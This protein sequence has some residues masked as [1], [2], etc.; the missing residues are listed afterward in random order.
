MKRVIFLVAAFIISGGILVAQEAITG[1]I[2]NWDNG[3]GSVF[4]GM[5]TPT[6]VGTIDD[7]GALEIILKPDFLSEVKQ[8]MEAENADE[9]NK[10]K[11]SMMTLEKAYTCN[12]G[13]VE[14][15]NGDQH[16]TSLS[17]MGFFI[18]GS[19]E[20]QKRYGDMMPASSLEF[21]TAFRKLG[22]YIFKEGYSLDWYY[23]DEAGSV[24]GTCIVNS[25]TLSGEMY[26]RTAE[27]DLDF[28]KGWNLV[29][30]EVQKVFA[31]KDGKTYIEKDHYSTISEMPPGV[32][33][34]FVPE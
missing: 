10:W 29:K 32:E 24:K 22:S 18:L 9:S 25:G 2:P 28:K 3:S 8:Q 27:Y 4:T 13:T 16:F 11:S 31:D 12:G 20:K 26:E 15:V 34:V 23:V 33:F 14:V 6:I 5:I 21:V 7:K 30:Y 1:S 19:M 17:T